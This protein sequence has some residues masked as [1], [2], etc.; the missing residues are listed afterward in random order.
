MSSIS[1]IH[2]FC[3]FSL[4]FHQIPLDV[5]LGGTRDLSIADLD[6]AE[7]LARTCSGLT[8]ISVFAIQ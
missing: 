6:L 4:N 3:I 8:V 1:N 2:K 7:V 5:S